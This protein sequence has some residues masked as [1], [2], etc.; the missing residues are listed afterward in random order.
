MEFIETIE[1]RMANIY[2]THQSVKNPQEASIFSDEYTWK[3]LDIL[4]AAGNNG[5]SPQEVHQALE[6]KL[7]TSVSPAKI[8]SLLKRLYEMGW[9]HRSYDRN[10]KT[11]HS[12]VNFQWGGI[13][14]DKEYEEIIAK[15][16]KDYI[17]GRLTPIF[18]EYIKTTIKDFRDDENN[19]KWL[20]KEDTFCKIC[21]FSHEADEFINS[22]LDEAT[23]EFME[24]EEYKKFMIDH[25]Y[26][27]KEED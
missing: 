10:D 19:K 16:E 25:H 22:L 18:L 1:N 3:I 12:I 9:V 4:R 24:S 23:S 17:A 11:H 6:K 7:R 13:I 5:L 20:P 2:Y 26:R 15:K 8:Y 14:L 21:Q 27:E